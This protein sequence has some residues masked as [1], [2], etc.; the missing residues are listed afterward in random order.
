MVDKINELQDILVGK[1]IKHKTSVGPKFYNVKTVVERKSRIV[2]ETKELKTFTETL[3]S[4][5]I[6]MKDIE[7]VGVSEIVKD[8][9]IIT[10]DLVVAETDFKKTELPL[11]QLAFVAPE[12]AKN[13][14]D[15]LMSI[16]KNLTSKKHLS[17]PDLKKAK[18]ACDVAGKI[19]DIE[20]VKLGY[21]AL[22][23]R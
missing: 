23:Y 21:L 7:V 14:S 9:I 3:E 4:I 8:K 11:K 22:N 2:I 20:K 17:E 18:L 12:A 16:F 6:L 10:S 13:V 19:I 15:G 5:D 1:Q